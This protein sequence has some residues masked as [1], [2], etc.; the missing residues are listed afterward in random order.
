MN[1]EEYKK[2]KALCDEYE[3]NIINSIIPIEFACICCKENVIMAI[4]NNY[5]IEKL[6]QGSWD[7]GTVLMISPG[8]GSNHDLSA[9]YGAI[10]DDCIE[11]FEKS[12]IILDVKKLVKKFNKEID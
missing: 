1:K 3:N 8:Y 2:M 9:Y 11:K 5:D 12:G 6:E 7:G 10:C 4:S